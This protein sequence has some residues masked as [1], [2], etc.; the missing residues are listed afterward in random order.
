MKASGHSSTVSAAPSLK[1]YLCRVANIAIGSTSLR[2]QGAAGVNE[3]ARTF[4]GG[5]TLSRFV[6]STETAFSSELEDQTR[7]LMKAL[8]PG[9]QN[10]GTARKALNLFL[11]E[12]YYHR[13][14]CEIYSFDRIANYL[15]VPLDSQVSSFLRTRARDLGADLPS[16][17]T[18]RA[19]KPEI[20]QRYQAFASR[21]AKTLGNG[22][23]RL[24]IDL[25][26]WRPEATQAA[27]PN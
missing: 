10:W 21:Y 16:W 7:K 1:Q 19:L 12:V 13:V 6:G 24:H 27:R 5:L 17:T 26:A 14:L 18:I 25:I 15:E 8:P 22:W 11:G 2:N 23:V 3:A 20:S 4:L 9:A